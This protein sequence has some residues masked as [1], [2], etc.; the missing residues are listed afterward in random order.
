MFSIFGLK[1]DIELNLHLW[2]Y[3]KCIL[4]F[5]LQFHS[6]ELIKTLLPLFW[7]SLHDESWWVHIRIRKTS[8]KYID[9][10]VA[11][12]LSFI[13]SLQISNT[14]TLLQTFLRALS[15]GRAQYWH[16]ANGEYLKLI[17]S[18]NF[19]GLFLGP[20][21]LFCLHHRGTCSTGALLCSS[22]LLVLLQV[23]RVAF[24]APLFY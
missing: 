12:L 9:S 8:N 2:I 4:M 19:A 3:R 23:L 15:I 6:L 10:S 11:G 24:C 7:D 1:M 17:P 21:Q 18:F 16:F 5:V 20:H 14:T 13:T 22:F